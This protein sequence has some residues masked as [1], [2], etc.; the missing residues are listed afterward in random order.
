MMWARDLG[1]DGAVLKVP[2]QVHADGGV[3]ET[4]KPFLVLGA[5]PVFNTDLNFGTNQPAK[6]PSYDK[7]LVAAQAGVG[8]KL[9]DFRFKSAGALYYYKNIE[10]QLSEPFTPVSTSD[11]GST[12]DSRPSFAQNG[13]TYMALRDIVPSPLN[14]NGTIDQWQYYGLATPFHD[15]TF[16]Q[17]IDYDH[18]EPFRISLIGEGVE[19][20]AFNAQAIAAKAVNN[21]GAAPASGGPAPFLGGNKGW[22]VTLK[23]GDA[24]MNHGGDW[25]VDLGYRHVESDSVVDGFTDTDFGGVLLGT[26]LQGFTIGASIGIAPGVWFEARW[27]SATA[28]VGP[29]YKNDTLETDIN[30]KF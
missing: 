5:F 6:Y 18:F 24:F 9:G 25:N 15:L 29:T 8:W 27:F 20:L 30:A 23:I 19:N 7:W 22:I 21:L 16:T 12:D 13:N 26:N 3:V 10:G 4:V 1:F 2:L 14:D 11:S 17:E 28:I